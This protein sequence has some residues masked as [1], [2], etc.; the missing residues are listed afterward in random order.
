MVLGNVY[1]NDV[2]RP[3]RLVHFAAAAATAAVYSNFPPRVFIP[4]EA[5]LYT[6]LRQYVEIYTR[7]HHFRCIQRM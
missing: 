6:L 3:D 2:L 5:L 7:L 1:W 4:S